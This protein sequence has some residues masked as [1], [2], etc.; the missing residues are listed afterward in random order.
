MTKTMVSHYQHFKDQSG[1][2][3]L[4]KREYDKNA[5]VN[6]PLLENTDRDKLAKAF[7][8]R[9][10]AGHVKLGVKPRSSSASSSP[11]KR[12]YLR[13]NIQPAGSWEPRAGNAWAQ[14][15]GA[16]SAESKH[17]VKAGPNGGNAGGGNS[18]DG[19]G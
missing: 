12:N 10:A 7:E 1:T 2:E 19:G 16:K 14:K 6:I 9:R 18:G 11:T 15:L 13:I 17:E 8:G 3:E 5:E 4:L